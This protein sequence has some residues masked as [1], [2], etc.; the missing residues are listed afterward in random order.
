MPDLVRIIMV[1]RWIPRTPY[2]LL[3][4][5]YMPEYLSDNPVSRA[6]MYLF[7]AIATMIALLVLTAGSATATVV[8]QTPV[9]LNPLQ[10]WTDA[11]LAPTPTIA[12]QVRY[13]D[14]GTNVFQIACSTYDPNTASGTI[15]MDPSLRSDAAERIYFHELGHLFAFRQMYAAD[16]AEATAI[17]GFP[18]GTAWRTGNDPAEPSEWFAE[19][20]ARC[21]MGRNPI[22]TANRFYFDFQS[23]EVQGIC[24][25]MARAALQPPVERVTF[26]IPVP[27]NRKMVSIRR[28]ERGSLTATV[29]IRGASVT[30]RSQCYDSVRYRKNLITV[31][32]CGDRVA[33]WS[34]S[35]IRA[36]L[37]VSGVPA[38][39]PATNQFSYSRV[40]ARIR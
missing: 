5:C 27:A 24:A 20:A 37:I 25:L 21:Y 23:P 12:V 9:D 10:A 14:C 19:A 34:R 33:V 36:T 1:N 28:F 18:A 32:T 17:L 22:L 4:S 26:R 39:V 29:R 2:W 11:A 40:P 6:A 16:L 38:E 35:N 15:S 30:S 3:I 13:G 8:T 7:K 31:G